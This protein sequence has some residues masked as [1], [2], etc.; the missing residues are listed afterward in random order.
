MVWCDAT[1]ALTGPPLRVKLMVLSDMSLVPERLVLLGADRAGDRFG[2]ERPLGAPYPDRVVD[3]I[4]DR[5][6]HAEGRGLAHPLG[7][8]RTVGLDRFDR[9][10]LHHG[11]A[12][13]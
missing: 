6:R 8:E 11:R 2:I 9:L 10:G 1:S 5:G 7:A 12:G 4:G 3:R 13:G